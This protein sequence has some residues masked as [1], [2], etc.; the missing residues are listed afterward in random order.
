MKTESFNVPGI[1]CN[2]CVQTITSACCAIEG[3][4]D[5]DVLVQEKTV[6]VTHRDAVSRQMIIDAISAAGYSVTPY[7]N[8]ISLQV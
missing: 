6:T 3:V 4:S 5:V 1:S 7:T 8:F 2:H